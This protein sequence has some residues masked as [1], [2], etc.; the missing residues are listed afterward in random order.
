MLDPLGAPWT[1]GM[2][3]RVGKPFWIARG[4]D[5]EAAAAQIQREIAALLPADMQPID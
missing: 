3:C 2:L 1:P 5:A 4:T